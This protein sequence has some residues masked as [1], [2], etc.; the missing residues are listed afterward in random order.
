MGDPVR[1]VSVTF[2]RWEKV[3][4]PSR[5]GWKIIAIQKIHDK[6]S[7]WLRLVGLGLPH[8]SEKGGS[9]RRFQTGAKEADPLE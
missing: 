5:G 7:D 2:R 8:R 6:F 3:V 4:Q 9:T 1:C